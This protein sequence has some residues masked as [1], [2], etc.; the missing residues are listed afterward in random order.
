MK[1]IIAITMLCASIAHA[2]DINPQRDAQIGAVADGATTAAVLASGGIEMVPWMPVTPMGIVAVTA[3]KVGLVEAANSLPEAQRVPALKG[4][5][6]AFMGASVNNLA[7]LAL[8]PSPVAIAFGVI[9]GIA[10]W[11]HTGQRLEM[12]AKAREAVQM[13]SN[14]VT[15]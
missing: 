1:R 11:N 4:M 3:A 7:A 5:S 2:E 14:E 6:G 15:E 10:A 13:A 8:I 12:Q 9:A